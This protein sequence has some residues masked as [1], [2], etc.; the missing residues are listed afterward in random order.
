[1]LERR[2]QGV[3]VQPEGRG[4]PSGLGND[5]DRFRQASQ[6]SLL[7]GCQLFFAHVQLAGEGCAFQPAALA[8]VSEGRTELLQHGGLLRLG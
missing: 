4:D 6:I 7:K 3:D 8:R 5:E 2:Q 1:L